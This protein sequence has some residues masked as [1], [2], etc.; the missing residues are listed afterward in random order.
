MTPRERSFALMTSYVLADYETHAALLESI[1][2]SAHA[3]TLDL[4]MIAAALLIN[5][6]KEAN[7]D[8]KDLLADI[9]IGQALESTTR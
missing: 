6:S 9:A 3:Q 2:P 5:W 1:D 4:S 7:I 8:P